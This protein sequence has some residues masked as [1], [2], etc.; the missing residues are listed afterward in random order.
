EIKAS[1]PGQIETGEA[2]FEGVVRVIIV[3]SD[4]RTMTG[5]ITQVLGS[6][7]MIILE[8]GAAPKRVPFSD[9]VAILPLA[10]K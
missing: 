1:M 10:V 4:G 7:L 9:I 8:E 5:L 2:S 6:D 3:L